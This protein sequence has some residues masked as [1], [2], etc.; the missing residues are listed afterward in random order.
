M[1]RLA[2]L[3]AAFLLVAAFAT[4]ASAHP[5]FGPYRRPYFRPR[6]VAP[7]PYVRPP[8]VYRPPVYRPYVYRPYY[9]PRYYPRP[10]YR[11]R[12]S[13]GIGF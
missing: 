3:F 1:K 12:I 7:R 10:Y 4:Q 5:R 9:G 8:V 6:V 13:V 2:L 11:P